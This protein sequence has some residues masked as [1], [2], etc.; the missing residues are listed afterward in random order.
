M[1]LDA[2]APITT[3]I[4]TTA[5]AAM[6]AS[7]AESC[8]IDTF[9]AQNTADDMAMYVAGAFGESIQRDELADPCNTVVIA[10]REGDVAGYAMLRDEASGE[11]RPANGDRQTAIE[12]VRLYSIA[13]LIGRG[14]GA[15]LMERCLAIAAERGK[16]VVWLG[17]WERNARAIAFYERWGFADVGSQAFT[18]GRDVQTDRVMTRRVA[19][20]GTP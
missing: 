13:S 16:D 9:G 17:V 11:R 20:E 1:T 19:A 4:A 6:L 5:D 7:L 18:L 10:E 14:V 8:F 12:I 2:I 15:T 3:R